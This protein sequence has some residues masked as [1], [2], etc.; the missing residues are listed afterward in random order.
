V[1][2]AHFVTGSNSQVL[3]KLHD[4]DQREAPGREAG[5]VIHREDGGNVLVLKDGPEGIPE[6]ERGM[7]FGKGGAGHTGGFFRHRR[8]DVRVERHDGH[9]SATWGKAPEIAA[10]V[11]CHSPL[12]SGTLR[13]RKRATLF[14]TTENIFCSKL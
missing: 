8:D 1:V 6:R 9:P 4:R 5:L 3:P 13:V 12:P 2:L 7:A 11:L 14:F 10:S